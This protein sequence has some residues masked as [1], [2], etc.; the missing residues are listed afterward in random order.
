MPVWF[1]TFCI[2][3]IVPKITRIVNLSL[4]TGSFPTEFEYALLNH[5]LKFFISTAAA[6]KLAN[7]FVH[8]RLDFCNS[9]FDCLLIY[10]IYRL[11]KLQNS[12][13]R[14]VT[15]SFHFSHIT[16]TLKSLHWCPIFYRINFKIFCITHRAL[17]FDELFYISSLL[18][19]RSNTHSLRTTLF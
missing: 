9:L 13:A 3:N 2:D 15:N 4:N 18:T 17:F 6:F 11:Q 8:Y 10:F 12:V 16:P 7:A 19:H 1:Y 14:I 5:F